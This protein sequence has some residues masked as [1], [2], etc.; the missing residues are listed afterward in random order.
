MNQQTPVNPPSVSID[1]VWLPKQNSTLAE[2]VDFAWDVV[3]FVSI[4]FFVLLM[5]MMVYFAIRYRRRSEY[6]ITSDRDHN[7]RLEWTWT[8]VPL[9]IVIGLFFVGFKGYLYASVPPAE[10]YEIHV[11][12]QKWSWTFTYPNG[13]VTNELT[14]PAGRPIKLIMSST[15]VLHSFY[16]PEFRAKRDVIPGLYTTLWFQAKEPAESTLMCAEYCGGGG[17]GQQGSGH[18]A[19]W[20]RT[21]VLSAPDFDTWM[22]SQEDDPNAPPAE[23]GGKLYVT[24]GCAGCHTTD[25]RP[26]NGPTFKGL[27]GN[28]RSMSD[29]AQMAADENYLRE[30]ILQSQKRIVAGFGAIMPAFEGQLSDKEVTYL[31]EYIKS[32]K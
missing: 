15:D 8:L 12:A 7:A 21:H 6:D 30:S 23:K 24:R 22:R 10:A 16:V 25:G 18:S 4:A 14:I 19:M 5:G 20:T 26:G 31:I 29:G 28:M 17:D 3:M 13:V 27:F 1:T 2:S 9:A 32:V 11:T